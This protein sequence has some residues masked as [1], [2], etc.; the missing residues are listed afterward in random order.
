[1]AP[2][3]QIRS[4]NLFA[5]LVGGLFTPAAIWAQVPGASEL[6]VG[7]A[8]YAQPQSV[9]FFERKTG[10]ITVPVRV[11][12]VGN[13]G[14][15]GIGA[16]TEGRFFGNRLSLS[17]GDVPIMD[18]GNVGNAANPFTAS[19]S[20]RA[21]NFDGT[22]WGD[23]NTT[24]SVTGTLLSSRI[25]PIDANTALPAGEERYRVFGS[26]FQLG[27]LGGAVRG[28]GEFAWSLYDRPT[29][30]GENAAPMTGDGAHHLRLE[31]DIVKQEGRTASAYAFL[32]RVAPTYRTAMGGA[33][34]DRDELAVGGAVEFGRVAINLNFS[35]F[36]NNLD[37][38][39]SVLTMREDTAG[40]RLALDLADPQ[41]G[42]PLPSAIELTGRT[43]D[44]R[45][46]LD[47][48]SGP[49]GEDA[50]I[51]EQMTAYALAAHWGAPE[52]R[53]TLSYSTNQRDARRGGARTTSSLEERLNLTRTLTAFGWNTNLGAYLG[54][55]RGDVEDRR[56]RTRKIGAS[57]GFS[58]AA[59]SSRRFNVVANVNQNRIWDIGALDRKIRTTW[60]IRAG[61]EI[62]RSAQ[63]DKDPG[64]PALSVFFSARGNAPE[65][66]NNGVRRV[67][68]T[69]GMAGKIKF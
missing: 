7:T 10:K 4:L 30:D 15:T 47:R 63:P 18:G 69:M 22:I 62:L 11:S 9:D 43:T 44:R 58:T 19:R 40:A 64:P 68:L 14:F 55:F 24:L 45:G 20:Q 35:S 49:I 32:R 54:N 1:M 60:E 52:D 41:L 39:P 56:L 3:R 23:G 38:K 16:L 8:G 21:V 33:P 26:G 57:V 31:A 13:G 59:P 46:L 66:Q 50:I 29:D 28:S 37:G 25:K 67:D 48:L 42:F 2:P 12:L 36:Q 51:G 61:A 5:I 34:A 27:L 65:N 6:R 17:F 53:I